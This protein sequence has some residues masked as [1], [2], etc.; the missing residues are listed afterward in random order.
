MLIEPKMSFEPLS[1]PQLN[2]IVNRMDNMRASLV[3]SKQ[4]ELRRS[5]STITAKWGSATLGSK[6][7]VYLRRKISQTDG[8]YLIFFSISQWDP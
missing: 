2:I 8:E 3:G 5:D 6:L 4:R 7:K 1:F